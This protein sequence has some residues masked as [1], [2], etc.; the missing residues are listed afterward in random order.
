MLAGLSQCWT[1]RVPPC[2][3]ASAGPIPATHSA[4][5]T[6]STHRLR[7]IALPPLNRIPRMR[8]RYAGTIAC[9]AGATQPSSRIIGPLGRYGA[10]PASHR[11]LLVQPNVF[12]PLA[13]VDAVDHH[14]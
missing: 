13:V 5:A 8:L 9:A 1:F 11:L 14:R 6:P 12:Q 10:G 7:R 4:P 3:W 2:F